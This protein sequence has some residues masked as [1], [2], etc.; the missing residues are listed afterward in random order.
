MGT[1]QRR[2]YPQGRRFRGRRRRAAA[3]WRGWR[4]SRMR[5]WRRGGRR[6]KPSPRWRRVRQRPPRRRLRWRELQFWS[7]RCATLALRCRPACVRWCVLSRRRM[8]MRN[9]QGLRSKRCLLRLARRPPR[10]GRRSSLV[11]PARPSARLLALLPAQ[12]LRRWFPSSRYHRERRRE[13]SPCPWHRR[14]PLRRSTRVCPLRHGLRGRPRP[15]RHPTA[16]RHRHPQ[17]RR[18]CVAGRRRCWTA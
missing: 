11:R 13:S 15:L 7:K 9:P 8:P 1:L 12:Q 16:R 17:R 18:W 14:S 4:S 3:R 6:R 10:S 5:A 2:Q